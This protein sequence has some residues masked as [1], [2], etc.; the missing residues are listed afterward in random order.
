[1]VKNEVEVIGENT[2]KNW[3]TKLVKIGLKMIDKM[4]EKRVKI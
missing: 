4:N 1:M 3:S 2:A